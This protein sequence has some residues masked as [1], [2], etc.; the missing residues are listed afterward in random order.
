LNET[1]ER[2]GAIIDE[3]KDHMTTHGC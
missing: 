2:R 3:L 1:R